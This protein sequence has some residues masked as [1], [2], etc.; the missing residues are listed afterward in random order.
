MNR[1]TIIEKFVLTVSFAFFYTARVT[2]Q[3]TE[4]IGGGG[5]E[6]VLNARVPIVDFIQLL[7]PSSSIVERDRGIGIESN[8]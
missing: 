6:R 3:A 5:G 1:E 8:L 4:A 2:K 7:F